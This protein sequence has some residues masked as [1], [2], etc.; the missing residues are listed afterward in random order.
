MS[1]LPLIGG[2]LLTAS[3]FF[4]LLL[5]Q[6]C[7]GGEEQTPAEEGRLRVGA[8]EGDG[9]GG[10]AQAG[11]EDQEDQVDAIVAKIVV[12]V[13]VMWLFKAFRHPFPPLPA[14]G[15]HWRAPPSPPF[16]RRRHRRL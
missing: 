12:V 8:Q 1:L 4:F 10:G 3:L 15:G 9:R 5:Q 6:G 7:Q 2:V 16:G 14:P 13:T 11:G